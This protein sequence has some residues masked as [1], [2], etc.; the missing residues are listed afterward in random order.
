M[1]EFQA[2]SGNS[3]SSVSY[4]CTIQ[5]M[6]FMASVSA[7]REGNCCS[8]S[9]VQFFT[10]MSKHSQQHYNQ[11]FHYFHYRIYEMCCVQDPGQEHIT[12]R[13]LIESACTYFELKV[14][15]PRSLQVF[16]IE[17]IIHATGRVNHHRLR[18]TIQGCQKSSGRV[19]ITNCI[20]CCIQLHIT[21]FIMVISN[22]QLCLPLISEDHPEGSSMKH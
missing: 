7:N 19:S 3:C 11:A 1:I 10:F 15:E 6:C 4:F 16:L 22:P 8:S 13:Q 21:R 18:H 12:P 9:G 17:L 14:E 20:G 5:P 2:R